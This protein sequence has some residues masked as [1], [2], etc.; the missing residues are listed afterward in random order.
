MNKKHLTII[1]VIATIESLTHFGVIAADSPHFFRATEYFLGWREDLPSVGAVRPLLP[2]LTTT[3]APLIGISISYAVI[4]AILYPISGIICYKLTQRLT[5]NPL[6]SLISS[7]MFLTSVAM[8]AFGASAYYMGLTIF[9]EF[10]VALLALDVWR[11]RLSALF[12]GIISGILALSGEA[13]LP[14]I[15]FGGILA[16]QR[17][18][19]NEAMTYLV[20][21]A[22]PPLLVPTLLGCNILQFYLKLNIGYAKSIG[23]LD[24]AHWFDPFTRIKFLAAGTSL[25]MLAGLIIGFLVDENGDRAKIFYIMFGLTFLAWL[26]W[27]PSERRH[28]YIFYPSI[29]WMSGVGVCW[30]CET[31]NQKPILSKLSFK[32]W[33]IILLALNALLSNFL[34]AQWYVGGYLHPLGPIPGLSLPP[35]WNKR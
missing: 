16:L 25:L 32:Q 10:L 27:V 17:R 19:Y 2:F 35:F 11:S 23:Y 28:V 18:K 31:L 12:R 29:S 9:S 1:V 15:L 20:F 26:T 8:I 34:A 24:P 30:L 21:S 4:N 6:V 22:L 33:L 14:Y 13:T 7:V 5:K 3:L